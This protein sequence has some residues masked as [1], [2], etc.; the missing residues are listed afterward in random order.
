MTDRL[1]YL[2]AFLIC[3]FFWTGFAIPTATAQD[4]GRIVA[5]VDDSA[6][7]MLDLIDRMALIFATTGINNT[8]DNQKRL[9]PQVLRTLIDEQLQIQ[10]GRRNN[11]DET[12]INF[13]IAYD[14]VEQNLDLQPG[15]LIPF[16]NANNLNVDTLNDQLRAEVIWTRLVEQRLRREEIS[17]DDIDEEM[18]RLRVAVNQPAFRLAE[19]FLTVDQ[20]SR[21]PE[22]AA[23]MD[24]LRNTLLSGADFQVLAR[25]FSQGSSRNNG[26]DLGWI[27]ESQLSDELAP[28][29]TAMEPGQLSEPIRVIGG[30]SIILLIDKRTGQEAN[31]DDTPLILRQAAFNPEEGETATHLRERAAAAMSTIGACEDLDALA[32]TDPTIAVGTEIPVRFG[33]LQGD[34]QQTV[35]QLDVG[36]TS[37]PFPVGQSFA[38]IVVCDRGGAG[39][40]T[41]EQVLRSLEAQKFDLISRSYLRNLRRAA[42]VEIRI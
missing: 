12:N 9:L 17:E 34:L 26:G 21:E 1:R 2:S 25:Q 6:I 8:P 23:N 41:R 24:R 37:D 38:V 42:F 28:V 5:V 19:I 31:P 15:T 3:L 20:P 33:D 40:P 18:E 32:G 30:F 16:L 27:V 11:F 39:M 10:E 14:L 29:V 22:V 7:T 36:E 4:A 13:E 35:G